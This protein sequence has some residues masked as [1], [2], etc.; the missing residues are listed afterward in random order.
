LTHLLRIR[1]QVQIFGGDDITYQWL[2]SLADMNS[3]LGSNVVKGD[4]DIDRMSMNHINE[5]LRAFYLLCY[6]ELDLMLLHR[7]RVRTV[8][9]PGTI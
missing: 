1:F 4:I 6:R 7:L 2:Q 3:L 9:A 5:C 8:V